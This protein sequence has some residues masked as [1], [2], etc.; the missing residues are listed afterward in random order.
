MTLTEHIRV[1]I[2]TSILYRFLHCTLRDKIVRYYLHIWPICN[3]Y[4]IYYILIN[5]YNTRYYRYGNF[6]YRN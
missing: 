4:C 3:I 5:K 6:N 2:M 1:K